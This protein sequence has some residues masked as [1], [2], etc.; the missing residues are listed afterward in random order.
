MTLASSEK[1]WRQPLGAKRGFFA[2]KL[3]DTS[4]ALGMQFIVQLRSCQ[5]Q[6]R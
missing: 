4:E 3:N 2:S 5:L 6:L 1:Q